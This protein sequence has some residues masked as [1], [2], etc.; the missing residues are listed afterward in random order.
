MN[1]GPWRPLG[2]HMAM[3]WVYPLFPRP[4]LSRVDRAFLWA[5]EHYFSL[6]WRLGND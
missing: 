5:M 2:E 1:D 6:F 3:D 4:L